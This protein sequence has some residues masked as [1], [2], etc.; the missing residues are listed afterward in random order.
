M[1]RIATGCWN[2]ISHK[3]PLTERKNVLVLVT[4]AQILVTVPN[5]SIFTL[6]IL[7]L[8]KISFVT[9]PGGRKTFLIKNFNSSDLDNELRSFLQHLEVKWDGIQVRNSSERDDSLKPE[10]L[11]LNA[12]LSL[13]LSMPNNCCLYHLRL[14]RYHPDI[15]L[16]ISNSC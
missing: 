10:F 1:N 4:V 9:F 11:P 12:L 5:W 3:F 16:R 7:S 6:N 8:S 2:Y 15:Y 14:E 13:L